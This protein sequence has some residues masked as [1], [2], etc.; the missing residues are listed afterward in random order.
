MS[1]IKKSYRTPSATVSTPPL[2]PSPPIEK[3]NAIQSIVTAIRSLKNPRRL[4]KKAQLANET[5][6]AHI[7]NTE[8]YKD[9]GRCIRQD[10][11]KAL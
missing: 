7:L 6:S 1:S 9:L 11:D 3:S 5:W 2:T 4:R 10:R 8:E